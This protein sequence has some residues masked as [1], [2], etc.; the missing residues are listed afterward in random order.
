MNKTRFNELTDTCVTWLLDLFTFAIFAV[1]DTACMA[2]RA[3][4]AAWPH[5]ME[6]VRYIRSACTDAWRFRSEIMSAC[7]E[8]E[9]WQ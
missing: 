4:R 1:Y 5:R 6:Y 7:R 2:T 9:I 3:V 8:E